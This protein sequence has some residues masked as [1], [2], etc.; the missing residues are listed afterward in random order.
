M[1]SSRPRY[2]KRKL[3]TLFLGAVALDIYSRGNDL[4]DPPSVTHS[5]YFERLDRSD[6]RSN[7]R[8]G[9]LPPQA[10][11]TGSVYVEP[12]IL[13]D[14]GISK[15][16]VLEATGNRS[17]LILS[18]NV[19]QRYVD[20][21]GAAVF[22]GPDSELNKIYAARATR[23]VIPEFSSL[24][25]KMDYSEI[26]LFMDQIQKQ[27]TASFLMGPNA[28]PGD[29][30]CVIS[31][32][33]FGTENTL[34][35]YRINIHENKAFKAEILLHELSHC[36]QGG[37]NESSFS[38]LTKSVWHEMEADRSVRRLRGHNVRLRD[39]RILMYVDN[40]IASR[41]L[42]KYD[43]KDVHLPDLGAL[44]D[45]PT[46]GEV[47]RYAQSIYSA[48]HRMYDVAAPE[49]IKFIPVLDKAASFEDIPASSQIRQ[50]NSIFR[51]MRCATSEIPILRH[52]FSGLS[53]KNA[54][55]CND[56]YLQYSM[57]MKHPEI[58]ALAVESALAK[59]KFSDD[60]NAQ[61]YAR[62]YI[63]SARRIYADAYQKPYVQAI[64]QEFI[65]PLASS[66]DLRDA[67][68]PGA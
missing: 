61:I 30:L 23:D 41:A 60:R 21:G 15:N 56:I 32:I 5:P 54:V 27:I 39:T 43:F 29:D 44:S 65:R 10:S 33:D 28:R 42:D 22:T 18:N 40:I 37:I 50:R 55:I 14:L 45:Q 66:S 9:I 49:M 38:P 12:A 1:A 13:Q 20:E 31:A 51:D 6:A 63:S 26:T 24:I 35:R 52:I 36:H 8:L 34:S 25:K 57:A 53:G 64:E 7:E 46:L 17:V 67:P 59:G 4:P 19:W 68:V 48:V 47:N 58:F 3:A 11:G 16:D 2:F 62:N